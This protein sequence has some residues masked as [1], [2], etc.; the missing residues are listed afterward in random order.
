[1]RWRHSA[2]GDGVEGR[3]LS[4]V[5][6]DIEPP[7]FDAYAG[8]EGLEVFDSPASFVPFAHGVGLLTLRREHRPVK[9]LRSDDRRGE[10]EERL[11]AGSVAG[12]RKPDAGGVEIVTSRFSCALMPPQE[13]SVSIFGSG[14]SAI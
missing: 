5:G 12:R 6:G 1:M 13:A 8:L 7:V 10:D 9:I 11:V 3:A 4:E 2:I 14:C